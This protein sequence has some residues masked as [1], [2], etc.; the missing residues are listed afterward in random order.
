MREGGLEPERKASL[1]ISKPPSP[2]L[3]P[4]ITCQPLSPWGNPSN[5]RAGRNSAA[6]ATERPKEVLPCVPHSTLKGRSEALCVNRRMKQPSSS[7]GR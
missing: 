2:A 3:P 1:V 6:R 7:D 4:E 5:W